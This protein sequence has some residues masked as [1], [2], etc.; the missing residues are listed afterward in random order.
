MSTMI[1]KTCIIK[2]KLVVLMLWL[3][4]RLSC[5]SAWLTVDVGDLQD[6]QQQLQCIMDVVGTVGALQTE[7]KLFFLSHLW[8][9]ET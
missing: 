7:D 5:G 2:G 4:C 1:I 6:W 3:C 8:Y 9:K